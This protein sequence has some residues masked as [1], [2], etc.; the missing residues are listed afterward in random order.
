VLRKADERTPELAPMKGQS[1]LRKKAAGT[2]G[3]RACWREPLSETE[4]ART[5]KW[6]AHGPIV[7]RVLSRGGKSQHCSANFDGVGSELFLIR[8]KA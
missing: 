7:G 6:F 1:A 8:C 4:R 2:Q 3:V 5:G